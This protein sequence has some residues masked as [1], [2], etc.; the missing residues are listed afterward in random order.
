MHTIENSWHNREQIHR[1]VQSLIAD[2]LAEMTE[3]GQVT[4]PASPSAVR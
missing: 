2:G 3:G 1:A 4:L